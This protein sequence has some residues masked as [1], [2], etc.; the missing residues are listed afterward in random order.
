MP[1]ENSL[2]S[3]QWTDAPG[4]LSYA[5][6]ALS[7]WLTNIFW[8]RVMAVIGLVL[9][10]IYFRL[11]GGGGL[12]VGIGWDVV[13]ILINAYQ[14]YR[15]VAERR[16]LASLAEVQMLRQGALSGLESVHLAALLRAGTWADYAAGET[17]TVEGEPVRHLV[18]ICDGQ[19]SVEAGGNRIATLNSG[20][21]VGEM[22]FLSGNPASATV[23]ITHP[24]RAF[25]FDVQKLSML[26]RTN[27]AVASDFHR[28]LGRDLARKLASVH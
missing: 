16:A 11:A 9:E 27:E 21:F 4:H 6:I 25:V 20:A 14:I 28:L 13:F 18:L 3:F 7:Y 26:A 17:L 2:F 23:R 5:I 15:L 1:D 10:I 12:H 24:T 22:A 19:A 8:L